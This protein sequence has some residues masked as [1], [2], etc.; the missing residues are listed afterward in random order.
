MFQST[1]RGGEIVH[2]TSRQ[3]FQPWWSSH[4]GV[5]VE[6][7]RLQIFKTIKVNFIIGKPSIFLNIDFSDI[8]SSDK[9]PLLFQFADTLNSP[10]VQRSR[11]NWRHSVAHKYYPQTIQQ[12]F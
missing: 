9:N 12:P 11:Q 6:G 2:S 4:V 1:V 7:R 3:T 10:Y 5:C 8:N